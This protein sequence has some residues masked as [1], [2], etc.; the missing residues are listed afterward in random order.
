MQ[1]SLIQIEEQIENY[2]KFDE[3]YNNRFSAEKTILE[4][5]HR[6][7]LEK[8]KEA[9]LTEAETKSKKEIKDSL[10][11]LSRFLRAAAARRQ[12]GDESDEGKAFEGAL[13]LVYGG[14]IGAVGAMEKLIEGSDEDCPTV[15]GAPSG[16]TC[17]S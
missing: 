13:L 5:S 11:V 14:D 8:A 3:D 9:A 15:H 6:Q 10:L 2:K 17:E 12:D 16:F 4:T 7:E 1:A